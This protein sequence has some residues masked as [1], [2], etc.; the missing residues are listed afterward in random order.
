MQDR[1]P[2]LWIVSP[3]LNEEE[4]LP[5]TNARLVELLDAMVAEGMIGDGSRVIYVDDG[6]TDGT[7]SLVGAFAA[8]CPGRVGGVRLACNRGHQNALLAG[9]SAAA[10]RADAVITIDADLQDDVAV[11]R[12]MVDKY[13]SGKEIV[14]GVRRSRQTDSWFKRTTARV[15]YWIME[16]LGVK[17]VTDHADFRLMNRRVVKALL[18]YKERNIFIRGIVPM[19][20]RDTDRVYYDR[21]ARTAGQTKY[22]LSKMFN[23]AVDGISSFSVKPVRMVFAMGLVFLLVALLIFVYALWS[24]LCGRVVSGWT[25]LILSVWTIGAFI[26]IGM[27][28]IGEYIGKIYIEVKN[29]PRY[30]IDDTVGL[31]TDDTAVTR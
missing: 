24:Y 16:R 4:V 15:F 2:I 22:T 7:W 6:S 18:D 31:E 5:G 20:S 8:A 17:T 27:G 13:K 19:L 3:C 25:S 12:E 14:Y 26:L 29:R 28:I 11:I 30:D 1:L 9:L 23:F 21:A 10:D